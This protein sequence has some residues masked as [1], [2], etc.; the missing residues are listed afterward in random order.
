[1]RKP[2]KKQAFN[3]AL[4]SS[5]VLW[6]GLVTI[7][8][9]S[10]LAADILV[11]RVRQAHAEMQ[12]E[13]RSARG[14]LGLDLY[15]V[16]LISERAGEGHESR[17]IGPQFQRRVSWRTD[18]VVAENR[19]GFWWYLRRGNDP[20]FYS[21]A[22]TAP[23]CLFALILALGPAWW[24]SGICRRRGQKRLARGHCPNCNYDLRGSPERCPECGR[25][26]EESKGHIPD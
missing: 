14:A 8:I 6:F 18:G 2:V 22:V 16:H 13:F 19:F 25:S 17:L 7:W 21:L 26:S 12:I 4:V 23:H 5:T 9:R 11:W 15:R 24:L 20:P 1:M 10:H 3:A